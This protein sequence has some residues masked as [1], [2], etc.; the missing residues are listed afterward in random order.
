MS[1]FPSRFE[2]PLPNTAGRRPGGLRSLAGSTIGTNTPDGAPRVRVAGV[3]ADQTAGSLAEILNRGSIAATQSLAIINRN[4]AAADV[5]FRREG[6]QFAA[7]AAPELRARIAQFGVNDLD[8]FDIEAEVDGQLGDG[9][10]P[11]LRSGFRDA[12]ARVAAA[13]TQDRRT[14]LDRV[15]RQEIT[16]SAI[17]GLSTIDQSDEPD[18]ALASATEAFFQANPDATDADFARAVVPVLDEAATTGNE[19]L[20]NLLGGVV[21]SALPEQFG[22]ASRRLDAVQERRAFEDEQAL[23][24]D[25]SDAAARVRI[26]ELSKEAFQ[27]QFGDRLESRPTLREQIENSFASSD[28]QEI[29]RQR[30]RL[31]AAAISGSDDFMQQRQELAALEDPD[32]ANELLIA[33]ADQRFATELR[34]RAALR[35]QQTEVLIAEQIKAGRFGVARSMAASAFDSGFLDRDT[36]TSIESEIGEREFRQTLAA[37]DAATL[38]DPTIPGNA[39]TFT[40]TT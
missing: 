21:E 11:A 31:E 4:R 10:D 7:E 34:Q 1:R 5:Q 26:G 6:Q 36:R 35:Q 20:F 19:R 38:T 14:T 28:N 23:L 27:R 3:Q 37:N 13:E 9:V 22:Q 18:T 40:T 17:A 8:G 33:R 39:S 16:D 15:T 30:R 25:I 32:G 12:L 24:G 29:I 2:R